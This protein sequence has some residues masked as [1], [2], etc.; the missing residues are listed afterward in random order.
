MSVVFCFSVYT[1]TFILEYSS[2][3]SLT[4]LIVAII[5][6]VRPMHS[7]RNLVLTDLYAFQ[8]VKNQIYC[9]SINREKKPFVYSTLF[10]QSVFSNLNVYVCVCR[11]TTDVFPIIRMCI[12]YKLMHNT[13]GKIDMCYSKSWH[14]NPYFLPFTNYLENQNGF[15]NK[16]NKYLIRE[17]LYNLYLLYLIIKHY[18][19]VHW[20][21]F[22]NCLSLK[23]L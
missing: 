12:C 17:Y 1:W 3:C 8:T 13:H 11:H 15:F 6:V 21:S 22:L 18:V 9:V 10:V 20:H 16:N 7:V 14:K 5:D 19:I 2:Q 4:A 23:P